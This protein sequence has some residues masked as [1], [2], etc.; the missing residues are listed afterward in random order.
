M[1]KMDWNHTAYSPDLHVDGIMKEKWCSH[2]LQ[3]H[4]ELSF[5]LNLVWM[6][7]SIVS[8][9]FS[10]WCCCL[11]KFIYFS[12][13]TGDICNNW[14]QVLNWA[15]FF[16]PA[17]FIL[18]HTIVQVVFSSC[19]LSVNSSSQPT[20]CECSL[21]FKPEFL[22]FVPCCINPDVYI[23]ALLHIP[24]WSTPCLLNISCISSFFFSSGD[25]SHLPESWTFTFV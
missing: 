14:S 15:F 12:L 11:S 4:V 21:S 22:E 5:W 19:C 25:F 3:I 7:D 16:L 1:P 20:L 17:L 9:C 18:I 8:V 10:R 6:F 13:E 24:L 2:L 23:S